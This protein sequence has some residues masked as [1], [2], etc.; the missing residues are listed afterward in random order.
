MDNV[1]KTL[2][3]LFTALGGAIGYFIGGLDGLMIALIIFV[4]MDYITG[5]MCAIVKH[6]LSSEIGFKGIFKKVVIFSLVGVAN[7]LDTHVIG[8][9]SMLR[10]AIIFFYLSNEGVSIL[11]NVA[12]LGIPIPKQIIKVLEQLRKKAGEDE[13]NSESND[14]E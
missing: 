4:V 1:W 5:I 13:E 10:S 2:Q 9:G 3:T 11:E 6:K 14:K 8:T 12:E 7:I